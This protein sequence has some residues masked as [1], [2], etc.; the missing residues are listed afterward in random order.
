MVH[1]DKIFPSKNLTGFPAKVNLPFQ[2][3][4][5]QDP[6]Q[7]DCLSSRRDLPEC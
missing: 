7:N 6:E 3:T 4:N 1:P 2:F 5:Q